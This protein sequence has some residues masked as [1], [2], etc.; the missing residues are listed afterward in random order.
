MLDKVFL[1]FRAYVELTGRRHAY[2]RF[3]NDFSGSLFDYD[4]I[5]ITTF[6]DLNG[7][8]EILEEL[9]RKLT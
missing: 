6:D 3:F 5:E 2:L 9:I 8:C 7:L 4:D 1:L